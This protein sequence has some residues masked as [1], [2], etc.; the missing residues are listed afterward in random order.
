[1]TAKTNTI[2]AKELN[3]LI[4]KAKKAYAAINQ[5]EA[6]IG[7]H[8]YDLGETLIDLKKK[9]KLKGITFDSL[10]DDNF[11]FSRQYGYRMIKFHKIQKK[12]HGA[13]LLSNDAYL[14]NSMLLTLMRSKDPI[15]IWKK[16]LEQTTD[17][18]TIT[19]INQL[20]GIDKDK[21]VDIK[22]MIAKANKKNIWKVLLAVKKQKYNPSYDECRVI[23]R[24]LSEYFEHLSNSNIY[25]N[26]N[27][28]K[29]A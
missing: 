21:T 9:A 10:C 8:I 5:Q 25:N 6:K 26:K 2:E 13:G 24:Y 29:A 23:T 27:D 15:E 11:D 17:T 14:S 28:E 12:L 18:P 22:D 4:E 7:K 1:M 3:A 20:I 19:L 16:A